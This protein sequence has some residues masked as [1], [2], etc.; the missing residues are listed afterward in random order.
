MFTVHS[1]RHSHVTHYVIDMKLPLPI[2]QKHKGIA[3]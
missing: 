2:V 1:L 3:V